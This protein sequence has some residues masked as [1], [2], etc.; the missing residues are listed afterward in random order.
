MPLPLCEATASINSR[1]AT[2]H[3]WEINRET[4]FLWLILLLFLF[5]LAYVLGLRNPERLPHPFVFFRRLGDV[6][7]LRGI[8][9]AMLRETIFISVLGG[10]LGLG[11]GVFVLKNSWLT[12]TVLSFLGWGLWLPFFVLLATL[13]PLILGIIAVALCTCYHY[14]AARSV[15]GLP[16]RDTRAYVVRE[17]ILQSF[18]LMLLSQRWWQGWKWSDFAATYRPAQ[19]A[20]VFITILG[21]LLL[22]N[23]VFSFDF[24]LAAERLRTIHAKVRDTATW[25]SFCGFL[26]FA[27]IFLMIWQLIGLVTFPFLSSPVG[28]MKAGLAYSQIYLDVKV[29]LLELLGGIVLGTFIAVLLVVLL[30]TARGIIKSILLFVFPLLYLSPIVLWLLWFAT[31]GWKP[32]L[33]MEYSHKVIAV[34]F[35]SSY[36]LVQGLWAVRDRRLIVRW[37]LAVDDALPIAFVAMLFGELWAATAG[38]GFAMAVASATGQI[39]RG[40]YVV[41]ITAILLAVVS[42]AIKWIAERLDNGSGH[43]QN[44]YGYE[45]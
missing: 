1:E 9:R 11:V 34:G 16:D 7:F 27:V 40:L 38:L 31:L 2:P 35:L 15:L 25:I 39:D 5:D 24:E 45:S 30:S 44:F 37:L 43:A 8:A 21:F 19:G 12:Q 10:A 29:F 22:I 42:A 20:G 41:L 17:A 36:P 33:F 14:L 3:T 18:L 6:E 4:V 32:P 23:W 28:V 26:L 13:D